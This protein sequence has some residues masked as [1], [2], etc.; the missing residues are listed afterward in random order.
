MDLMLFFYTEKENNRD[1]FA[2]ASNRHLEAAQRH[3]KEFEDDLN[4]DEE[5][6][7]IGDRV[8]DKVFKS[9]SVNY[10]K[11]VYSYD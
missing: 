1:L 11:S 3:L 9:Y 10:G 6:D 4:S 5:E 2:E 8:L 7:D